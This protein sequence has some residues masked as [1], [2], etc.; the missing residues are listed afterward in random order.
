MPKNGHCHLWRQSFKRV[1]NHKA[2]TG[3]R[4]VVLIDKWSC[5]YHWEVVVANETW[6]HVEVQV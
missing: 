1:S 3:K 5:T 2:L 6:S 4:V